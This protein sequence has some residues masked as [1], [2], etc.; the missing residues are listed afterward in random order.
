MKKVILGISIIFCV[1][2]SGRD[3]P[4]AKYE[5]ETGKMYELNETPKTVEEIQEA[6]YIQKIQNQ[7][8][9]QSEPVSSTPKANVQ[10]TNKQN[11]QKTKEI[12]KKE[13]ANVKKEPEQVI[14]VKPR[15]DVDSDKTSTTVNPSSNSLK[16]KNILP[17][18][19]IE[20]SDNELIIRSEHK[21]FKKFYIDKENKLAFDYK[22]KVKFNTKKEILSGSNFKT[23]TV[24]NHQKGGYY[25]VAVELGSK[26]S[27]YSV[28]VNDKEIVIK[29]K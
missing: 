3:N 24:G 9:S 28:D 12:V 26:V 10:K 16:Q 23:I 19:N 11:K 4:F 17:F 14:Y 8:N 6:Q 5:E 22:A 25:R 13:L 18:L 1:T 29:L 20:N 15:A 21:M 27:K 2:L 7:I